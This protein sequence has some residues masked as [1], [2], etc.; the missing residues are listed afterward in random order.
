MQYTGRENDGSGLYYY[1]ARYYDPVLKGFLSED[2]I[3]LRG[4][5]NTYSYVRGN[6]TNFIDPYGESALGIFATAVV[7]VAGA[8]TVNSFIDRLNDMKQQREDVTNKAIECASN[9]QACNN[10]QDE[11]KQIIERARD[12]VDEGRK[13]K[14]VI[15]AP[16]DINKWDEFW[17]KVKT[18]C[19]IP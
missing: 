3:G 2:P 18:F 16:K 19:R 10:L 15:N 17:R 11:Q 1:R 8:Y 13:V 7:V 4:G 6:P 14:D 5:L 9:P 12:A